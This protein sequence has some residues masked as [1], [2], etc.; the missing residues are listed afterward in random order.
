MSTLFNF[1]YKLKQNY[2]NI[3]F[4]KWEEQSPSIKNSEKM[5]KIGV[6]K[7]T[8]DIGCDSLNIYLHVEMAKVYPVA[9][10]QQFR[11]TWEKT[12]QAL[13]STLKDVYN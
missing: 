7:A 2:E 11:M 13:T 4:C 5:D 9:I 8:I 6:V 12:E 10:A 3:S 1:H